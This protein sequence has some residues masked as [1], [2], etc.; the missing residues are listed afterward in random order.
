[1]MTKASQSP[2]KP[3][4]LGCM[5]LQLGYDRPW[6]TGT[7]EN[8]QANN[9][10][11]LLVPR[12]SSYKFKY[13][14]TNVCVSPGSLRTCLQVSATHAKLNS[15]YRYSHVQ[16][17]RDSTGKHRGSRDTH[18]THGPRT[19]CTAR[20]CTVP[21]RNGLGTLPGS[22]EPDPQ[23]HVV[24]PGDADGG[25]LSFWGGFPIGYVS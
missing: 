18:G 5:P 3:A 8:K 25:F 17:P 9:F 13:R 24:P 12:H 20:S 16:Y 11:C 14:R 2:P 22:P 7:A 6:M 1:M 19:H 15:A 10:A 4:I 23:A 21:V